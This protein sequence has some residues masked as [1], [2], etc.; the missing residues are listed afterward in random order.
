[1]VCSV[2]QED[3]PTVSCTFVLFSPPSLDGVGGF[4]SYGLFF[5]SFMYSCVF[6]LCTTPSSIVLPP[7][8]SRNAVKDI[9]VLSPYPCI[10]SFLPCFL[11]TSSRALALLTVFCRFFFFS[12]RPQLPDLPLHHTGWTKGPGVFIPLISFR[13]PFFFFRQSTSS[14]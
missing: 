2:G 11:V 8:K 7:G 13:P 3:V 5:F 10:L 12:D 14:A 9:L 4:F 1:M 6:I